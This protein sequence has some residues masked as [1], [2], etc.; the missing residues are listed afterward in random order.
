MPKQ[1]CPEQTGVCLWNQ[2]KAAAEGYTNFVAEEQYI[3]ELRDKAYASYLQ[4]ITPIKK[5]NENCPKCG[6]LQ[7][8]LSASVAD[9]ELPSDGFSP[10]S[11]SC[12][13]GNDSDGFEALDQLYDVLLNVANT[14]NSN[15]ILYFKDEYPVNGSVWAGMYGSLHVLT[16]ILV[17]TIKKDQ[18]CCN[19]GN[20]DSIVQDAA[21][22]I[23]YVN[24]VVPQVKSQRMAQITEVTF[25]EKAPSTCSCGEFLCDPCPRPKATWC[26]TT[27]EKCTKHVSSEVIGMKSSGRVT[28]Y[29]SR[30]TS[31]AICPA[32][33]EATTNCR[34]AYYSKT[35]D[36][37]DTFLTQTLIIPAQ[38]WAKWANSIR[39]PNGTFSSLSGPAPF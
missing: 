19:K 38:N 26:D 18:T 34:N 27:L 37:L 35:E 17:Y 11:L 32:M 16:D 5:F 36:S 25:P 15:R 14:L 20:Y 12:D 31:Y 10:Q 23:E 4:I 24:T 2:V 33:E 7:A 9:Y 13:C 29:T 21:A 30:L 39:A 22:W 28:K 1:N 6:Q 8:N 3:S